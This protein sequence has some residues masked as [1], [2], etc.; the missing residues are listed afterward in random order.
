G[1]VHPQQ[2]ISVQVAETVTTV[3]QGVIIKGTGAAAGLRTPAAGKT[4]TTNDAKDAWFTGY[5]CNL[6][7]S[8]WMGY[9]Q[10]KQM[11]SYKGQSVAGGT[12]PARIWRDF[13]IR[14]IAGDSACKFP[15]A[16]VGKKGTVS[17]RPLT[18]GSSSTRPRASTTTTPGGAS[19]SSSTP[20][21]SSTTVPRSTT[22]AA[23]T[24]TAAPAAGGAGQ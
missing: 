1:Q 4:G 21:A 17:G 5:T 2:L 24:T 6:T 10:P 12:F 23:P 19:T 20:G 7:A 14:A 9:E 22:S 18:R 8:V 11:K 13:M 15:P 3:L 16:E